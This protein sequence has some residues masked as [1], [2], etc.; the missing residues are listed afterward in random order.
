[1]RVLMYLRNSAAAITC[2]LTAAA[3][4]LFALAT[5]IRLSGER[6]APVVNNATYRLSLDLQRSLEAAR[7]A[8]DSSLFKSVSG[9]TTAAAH[10]TSPL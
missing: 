2:F 10:S 8:I 9:L 1:M 6:E 3:A 7:H 4:K 5:L